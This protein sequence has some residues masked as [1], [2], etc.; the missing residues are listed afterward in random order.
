MAKLP[1]FSTLEEEAEFWEVHSLT[2]YMDE[3][4]DVDLRVEG[5]SEDTYLTIRVTPETITTLRE[6][7]R[8]RDASLQGLLREWI[9]SVKAEVA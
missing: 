9:E 2:E 5:T 8:K 4:E 1:N 6:T 3:L 7:A